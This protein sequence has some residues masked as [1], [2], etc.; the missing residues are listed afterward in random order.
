M[1]N[2]SHLTVLVEPKRLESQRAGAAQRRFGL[3]SANHSVCKGAGLKDQPILWSLLEKLYDPPQGP[4]I[5]GGMMRRSPPAPIPE[6]HLGARVGPGGGRCPPAIS[7]EGNPQVLGPLVRDVMRRI[8]AEGD[9]VT[10]AVMSLVVGKGALEQMGVPRA[11]QLEW[12]EALYSLLMRFRLY[13][14]TALLLAECAKDEAQESDA[15]YQVAQRNQR[16][17]NVRVRYGVIQEGGGGGRSP[18]KAGGGAEGGGGGAGR[19]DGGSRMAG[20]VR[21]AGKGASGK[22]VLY[23]CA[24]C[25]VETK[26][27]SAQCGS[28]QRSALKCAVCRITVRGSYVWCQGCGHG[29]HREH[30]HAWFSRTSVLSQVCP[31]GCG[32]RC[33][34]KS[35]LLPSENG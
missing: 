21:S 26:G 15:F 22:T 13:N 9:V 16:D 10:C 28:C 23:V 29:G 24:N 27:E 32:H 31:T 18:S 20:G 19:G 6:H 12:V 1:L 7:L 34:P 5:G 33:N 2:H 30:M 25:G 8:C 3:C 17:T 35:F 4:I 11:E 14:T